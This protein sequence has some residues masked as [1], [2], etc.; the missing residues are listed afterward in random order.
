MAV[1]QRI[2]DNK[3][4]DSLDLAKEMAALAASFQRV[5][6]VLSKPTFSGV[7]IIPMLLLSGQFASVS[8]ELRTE[9]E[10]FYEEEV[11]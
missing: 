11:V 7:N 1:L 9:T 5:L 6:A 8:A 4:K 3:T 2:V 10:S